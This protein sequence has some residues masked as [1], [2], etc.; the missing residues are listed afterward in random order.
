M[1]VIGND[2]FGN[3]RAVTRD[4]GASTAE[5]TAFHQRSDKDASVNAEHHTL[6]TNRNQSSSGAHI[7]DGISSR[8]I[9]AGQGT[10]LTGA[11]GGNVALANLITMLRN[12][13]EF[14][15]STT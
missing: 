13:I 1:P 4:A 12:W 14:T 5:V 3:P 7:H 9:G 6:G 15:D 8:A 2:P 10:V 11:K